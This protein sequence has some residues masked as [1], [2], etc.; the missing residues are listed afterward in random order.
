MRARA[1]DQNYRTVACWL[2][3]SA[4]N[5]RKGTKLLDAHDA[6]SVNEA[7]VNSIV[8]QTVPAAKTGCTAAL[9]PLTA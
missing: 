6:E 9:Q 2:D 4:F 1:D 8:V 5:E 3:G 7:T